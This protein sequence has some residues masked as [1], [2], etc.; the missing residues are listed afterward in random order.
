M[1][2]VWV[3]VVVAMQS[4]EA[5]KGSEFQCK[6]KWQKYCDKIEGVCLTMRARSL[7]TPH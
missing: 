6:K 7:S 3:V 5:P 1:V 2:V 4:M